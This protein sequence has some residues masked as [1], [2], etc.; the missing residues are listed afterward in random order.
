MSKGVC[1][2]CSN[3]GIAHFVLSWSDHPNAYGGSYC[4]CSKGRQAKKEDE[5]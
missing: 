3:T 2:I 1:F 5:K 4:C